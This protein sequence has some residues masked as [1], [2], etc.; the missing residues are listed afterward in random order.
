MALLARPPAL[1][2]P[3]SLLLSL[4]HIRT[5][6]MEPT[7]KMS[8]ILFVLVHISYKGGIKSQIND[9][10]KSIDYAFGETFPLLLLLTCIFL[11]YSVCPVLYKI[12]R[13]R[14]ELNMRFKGVPLIASSTEPLTA[15]SNASFS[16]HFL[17][18]FCC[19]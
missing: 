8:T 18:I 16:L 1:P 4:T 9:A 6:S 3:L 7:L 19:S 12:Q 5:L 11:N 2:C 13:T 15:T 17:A 14:K 10:T